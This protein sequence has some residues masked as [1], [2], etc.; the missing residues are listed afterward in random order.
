MYVYDLCVPEKERER[1]QVPMRARKEQNYKQLGAALLV[2][3]IVLKSSICTPEF[4]PA[5]FLS[6]FISAQF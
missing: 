1:E 2:P 4:S 3:R 5:L 6:F